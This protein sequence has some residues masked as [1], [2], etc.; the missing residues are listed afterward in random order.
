MSEIEIYQQLTA[1]WFPSSRLHVQVIL[2][3]TRRTS[4]YSANILRFSFRAA[5]LPAAQEEKNG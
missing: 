3:S 2:R 1:S 4:R 5:R